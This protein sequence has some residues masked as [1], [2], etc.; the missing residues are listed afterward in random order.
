M[1]IYMFEADWYCKPCGEAIRSTID[2]KELEYPDPSEWHLN[3]SNTWPIDYDSNEGE[4][5]TPDHC[6]GRISALNEN[7]CGNI[8]CDLFLERPLTED[9]REYVRQLAEEGPSEI[10]Q[11]WMEYY[12]IKQEVN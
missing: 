2:T 9:G 11:Q 1:K 10:V 12:D 8:A 5:D 7:Y 6:A 3:D 4:S